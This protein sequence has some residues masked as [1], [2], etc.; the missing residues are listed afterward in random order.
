MQN[1]NPAAGVARPL[2]ALLLAVAAACS[3]EAPAA[4][5]NQ[6]AGGGPGGRQSPT[7]VLAATDVATIGHGALEE[8]LAVTGELRPIES[9]EVRARL[10]GDLTGVYV[11]EGDRVREG[12]L[13][14]QFEA[15]EQQSNRR[16]AEADRVAAEGEL[17]TASWNLEQ[18]QELYKAGAI[19]ELDLK[20]A[21]Q[22]VN[23]AR[24]RLAAADAR[25]RATS[26]VAGDT[27][28]LAPTTGIV[29][30]REVE[31]GEHVARGA[32]M[33]SV[34]RNDVLELAAAVP[35]RRAGGVRPGQP[36]RFSAD[37]RDFDGKVARV[38]PTIDPSTR[39]IMVYMQVANTG[40]T[41]KGNTFVT[42][43]IIGRTIP[44]ALGVPT[45]ALR[46]GG[47]EGDQQF[48]YRVANGRIDRTPVRV[49]VV[50]E[51][52]GMAEVLE[53]LKAGD[54]VVVGNVGTLGDGMQVQIAGGET[55]GDRR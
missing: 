51:R 35:A 12:Q 39:A 30:R 47:Q 40:G 27:R 44:D 33:F 53:G 10:E 29:E 38:S 54:R 48:V 3:K 7:I 52:A 28:V 15:S 6:R 5:A 2:I 8:G 37:G 43:R 18:S 41:L 22:A 16:S 55:V 25:V 19:P 23:A 31:T 46:Q 45:T 26:L 20:T 24:A 14:A 34:V 17:N 50:D 49:G 9:V 42:G 21:Q 11:R 13:L 1:R 32:P 36:V 4:G